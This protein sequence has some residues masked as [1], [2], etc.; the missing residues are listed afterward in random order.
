MALDTWWR[1][2]LSS[3]RHCSLLV[4]KA[5]AGPEVEKLGFSLPR[6]PPGLIAVKRVHAGSWAEEVGVRV[7]D[8]LLEVE[9]E[10][11]AEMTAE[12]LKVLMKCRPVSLTFVVNPLRS[13]AYIRPEEVPVDADSNGSSRSDARSSSCSRSSNNSASLSDESNSA[14]EEESPLSRYGSGERTTEVRLQLRQGRQ[15]LS[16]WWSLSDV[17]AIGSEP[18]A[19]LGKWYLDGAKPADTSSTLTAVHRLSVSADA[20]AGLS[21]DMELTQAL[22]DAMAN[23]CVVE[24]MCAITRVEEAGALSDIVDTARSQLAH[25]QEQMLVCK[26]IASF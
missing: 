10:H 20:N 14:S 24:L 3:K 11:V 12:R 5:A 9:G 1:S 8:V 25:L 19:S 17:G 4:R 13:F 26:A 16:D 2:S 22:S 15:S 6:L 23:G 21:S 7:A 18:R